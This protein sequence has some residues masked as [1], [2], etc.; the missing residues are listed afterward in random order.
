MAQIH[1]DFICDICVICGYFFAS[2]EEEGKEWFFTIHNAEISGSWENF[3]N[4]ARRGQGLKVRNVT[5]WGEAPGQKHPG[6]SEP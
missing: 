2:G 3:C 6:I 1:T 5:A 4:R